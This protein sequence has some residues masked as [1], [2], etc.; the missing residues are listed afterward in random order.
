MKKMTFPLLTAI[1]LFLVITIGIPVYFDN[2]WLISVSWFPAYMLM[3][4]IFEPG[5]KK[6]SDIVPD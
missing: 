5:E 6:S 3:E 4:I 1:V 2:G